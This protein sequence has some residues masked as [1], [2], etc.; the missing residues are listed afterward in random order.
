[1]LFNR[2][3]LSD[4]RSVINS[5]IWLPLVTSACL[6]DTVGLFGWR[7]GLGGATATGPIN[8][9]YDRFGLV[10]YGADILSMIIAIIL[11][12]L[13]TGFLGGS[14]NPLVFCA[15]AVVIQMA[16][17]IFFSAVVVPAIPKGRNTIIDLMHRYA[18]MKGAG[19]ILVV[20]AIYMILTALGTMA[21]ASMNPSVSWMTLLVTLYATMYVLHTK[22]PSP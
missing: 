7:Y 20:D 4:I 11:T 15:V 16:H 5:R 10:A 3:L 8:T 17:D 12:Q 2:M 19:G 21:L 13:V 18:T 22:G 6:V 9:W 14:W 1:M